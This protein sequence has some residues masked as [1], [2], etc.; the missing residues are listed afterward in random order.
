MRVDY[1][2]QAKKSPPSQIY[3][4]QSQLRS[5]SKLGWKFS[6]ESY[7]LQWFFPGYN[8]FYTKSNFYLFLWRKKGDHPW[9]KFL[10]Q[11]QWNT[12][13]KLPHKWTLLFGRE[14]M[15]QQWKNLYHAQH[16]SINI[17]QC[18]SVKD[19]KWIYIKQQDLV[20]L[21]IN[22]GKRQNWIMIKLMQL[23][24]LCMLRTSAIEVSCNIRISALT[25]IWRALMALALAASYLSEQLMR[26]ISLNWQDTF[27]G[28]S[29]GP[30]MT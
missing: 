29:F 30:N 14:L 26:L 5:W 20:L 16:H 6:W 4:N 9:Q 15:H 28:P 13:Y 2:Y 19:T 18:L 17:L 25:M 8:I 7:L 12:T 22:A 1:C 23:Q 10:H 11:L 3:L 21:E 27:N 24:I